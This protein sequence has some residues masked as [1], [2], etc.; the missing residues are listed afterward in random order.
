MSLHMNQSTEEQHDVN[1][2]S[3]DPCQL[4]YGIVGGVVAVI[5]RGLGGQKQVR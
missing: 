2:P 4:A 3:Q 5:V 1:Q